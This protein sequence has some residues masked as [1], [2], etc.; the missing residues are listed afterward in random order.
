MRFPVSTFIVVVASV[1]T[2]LSQDLSSLLVLEREAVL[3]GQLWRLFSAHLVHFTP[4]HLATD[5][6]VF[7]IA[8]WIIECK[9]LGY[10]WTLYLVTALMI[11]LSLLLIY[12]SMSSYGGLSGIASGTLYY[13]ALYG[14]REAGYRRVISG[15]LIA[16]LPVK[17][18]A[19]IYTVV[20]ILD[21]S[22]QQAFVPMPLSH[23]VGI[24]TALVFH[25]AIS[26]KRANP[27]FR[28][29]LTAGKMN[30]RADYA[31]LL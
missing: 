30:E 27:A 28:G 20:A 8:G 19:D 12:P 1:A 18:I 31:G 25:L 7:A 9:G 17:A 16:V 6:L 5:L 15:V 2:S 24:L 3:N 13:C 10:Y 14:I 11:S 23:I 21:A 26:R 22:G 29:A 4:T